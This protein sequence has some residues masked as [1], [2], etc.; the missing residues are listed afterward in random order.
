MFGIFKKA[1]KSPLEN[2]LAGAR[3]E[4]LVDL[5]CERETPFT[6]RANALI[7][8]FAKCGKI[9]A[10]ING[11]VFIPVQEDGIFCLW[12]TSKDP[13]VRKAQ[14]IHRRKKWSIEKRHLLEQFFG[15]YDQKRAEE[16][17]M[18]MRG[19][20]ATL[21][22][23]EELV[24]GFLSLTEKFGQIPTEQQLYQS[25]VNTKSQSVRVAIKAMRKFCT[26]R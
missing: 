23:F 10:E 8:D 16:L 12:V 26:V 7:N 11:I 15:E 5:L 2:L 14:T 19:H 21:R 22:V 20:H 13:E 17:F 18:A 4:E 1:D 9:P 6:R 25:G 24:P 3:P